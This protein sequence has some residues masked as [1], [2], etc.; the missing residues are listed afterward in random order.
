MRI[1]R[2]IAQVLLLAF[3]ITLITANAESAQK[4]TSGVECKTHKQKATYQAKVYTCIKS[5]KKLVWNT[6]VAIKSTPTATLTMAPSPTPTLIQTPKHIV[7][8]WDNI[9][10]NY[11]EIAT[12]VYN[13][14]QILIDS[15]Y[16]PKYKLTV[17]V[18]PNTKPS[19]IDPTAAFAL[20]SN[21]LKNFKQPDEVYAIYYNNSDKDWAK[22]FMQ[23]KEGAPWASSQVDITCPNVNNCENG[24]AG[25]FSNWQGFIQISVPNNVSWTDRSQ[26]PQ[27][28]IHEFVHVIQS[29]QR[30]PNFNNWTD[31]V[32]AWLSEGHAS[33]LQK[34]GGTK[35]LDSYKLNQTNQIKMLP[36]NDTLRDFSTSSIMRFYDAL[37]PG[38][39]NPGMRE[40]SYT[41]GYSTVEALVAIAGIDSVMELILQSTTGTPFN[42]AFKNVYGIE[43][44]AAA[45]ILAEVVSKQYK[46]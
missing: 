19:D 46:P 13:K 11:R 31:L 45:P 24:S 25:N 26:V 18:G 1:K 4:I 43:W 16:Q 21:L 12:D 27:Q 3:S 14:G 10:A 34:I 2:I 44:S 41:I 35:T 8:T 17:L 28:D 32:P 39:T 38:K 5:G 7:L 23:E 15:N 33:L 20:A 42:Q 6:G 22:R 30:K 40:Y 9:T 37:A 36:A 29:Y